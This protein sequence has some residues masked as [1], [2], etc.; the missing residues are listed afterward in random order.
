M[1]QIVF[2]FY[3]PSYHFVNSSLVWNELKPSVINF[4]QTTTLFCFALK[5][6]NKKYNRRRCVS[7]TTRGEELLWAEIALLVGLRIHWLYQKQLGKTLASK[8]PFCW[9]VRNQLPTLKSRV[10]EMTL[11][12]SDFEPPVKKIL[13]K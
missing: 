13:G 7:I 5:W 10:F 1:F 6:G 8:R 9:E 12:V 2:F 11:A 3:F 4:R